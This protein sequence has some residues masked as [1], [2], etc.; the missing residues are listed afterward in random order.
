MRSPRRCLALLIVAAGVMTAVAMPAWADDT[1]P[2][3]FDHQIHDRQIVMGGGTSLACARCHVE[4]GGRLVGRPDHHTCFGDCHG[5]LPATPRIG[6]KPGVGDRGKVCTA[7]HAPRQ[8]DAAYRGAATVSYPPYALD[9]D[10][11]TNF[12][13]QRHR[14]V[15][16]TTCHSP[17]PGPGALRPASGPARP[18]SGPARPAS[19]HSRCAGCHDGSGAPGHASNMSA[20]TSC[21]APGSGTPLPPRLEDH[22]I[23]VTAAFSHGRH[24]AR[25]LAGRIC[26]TCHAAI[27]ETDNDALP[28]PTAQVCA[29]CHDGKIAFAV[30]ASCTKCHREPPAKSWSIARPAKRFVH[31]GPHDNLVATTPCATC[32]PLSPHGEAQVAGHDTCLP[33][34][35]A[36]LG[37]AEPKFCG[38]CHNSTEP[39]RPLTVDRRPPEHTEFGANL[40]HAKHRGACTSC[41]VVT[42]TQQQLRPARGHVSCTGTTCHAI[43]SGP[44]PRLAECTGCHALSLIGDREK[45][46]ALAPWSVRERFDH[47][48]HQ[49]PDLACEACHAEADLIGPVAQL[50]TPAKATCAPCHDGNAAFD[51]T[52][53]GCRRCHGQGAAK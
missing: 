17:A 30:T 34:H 11:T 45:A 15:A 3:G 53:T 43:A 1:R 10:W 36:E 32:H 13:H 31:A 12:G 39:W 4:R 50:R 28:A 9:R 19:G 42:T 25:S 14:D 6:A 2:S 26:A 49:R 5:P 38:A 52:G 46:R 22:A 27:R 51:V 33:C 21:H 29:S 23:Q 44:A 7:C 16:C 18:A 20:C 41:H 37:S 48:S 24:A 8:L 35:A 47:R 40:D